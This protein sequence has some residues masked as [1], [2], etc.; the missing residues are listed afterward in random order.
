MELC[1]IKN[2]INKIIKNKIK[3][4]IKKRSK[5]K[6]KKKKLN[7]LLMIKNNNNNLKM[8]QINVMKSQHKK[9]IFLNEFNIHLKSIKNI[10]FINILNYFRILINRIIL[11]FKYLNQSSQLE[12]FHLKRL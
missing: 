1:K 6:M 4:Q 12:P 10:N 8:I 2:K 3:K 7:Q 9:W 11:Y 5:N